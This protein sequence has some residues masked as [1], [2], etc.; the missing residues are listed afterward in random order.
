M[1][2]ELMALAG[3]RSASG[4]RITL[5]EFLQEAGLELEDVYRSGSWSGLQRD[6]G[7]EV[8]APGPYET[9]IGDRLA[10]LL[11]VDD[12]LRLEAY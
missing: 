12:P 3:A 11:H 4:R 5:P 6:A 2:R 10:G 1:V 7:L 8:P 9:L